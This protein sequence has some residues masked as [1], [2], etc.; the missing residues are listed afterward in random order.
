MEYQ[1]LLEIKADLLCYGIRLTKEAENVLKLRNR[2]V[3]EKGFMHAA[4]FLIDD[5][6]INTCVSEK[7]CQSSPYVIQLYKDELI[8][9]KVRDGSSR[10]ISKID[11]L[12]LPLWCE[13]LSLIH[14]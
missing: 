4:H 3:L 10:F 9:E 2:Y 12:H 1:K 13:A 8:L 5:I 7:Y 6:I 11:V 14:I